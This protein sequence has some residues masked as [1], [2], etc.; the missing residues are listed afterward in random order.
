MGKNGKRANPE[1]KTS[2]V[3]ILK[4]NLPMTFFVLP[5]FIIMLINNYLPM[6]GLI[7][8]FKNMDN[9][10][11]IFKSPF[12]GFNNFKFLF[13][14]GRAFMITRNTV[15]YNLAFIILGLILSV[16]I[17]IAINEIRVR[18][19]AKAFQTII[20]LPYFLSFVVIGYIVYGFL[21]PELGFINNTLLPLLGKESIN[22]YSSLEYWPFILVFVNCWVY[23]GMNSIIY[24]ASMTAIDTTL[25]EAAVIDG[26]SKWNQ[27]RHITLPLIAPVMTIL[28][29]I[30]LGNIFRGNFGLFYQVPLANPI[31]IPVTD[32]LDTYIYR[33]LA[34]LGDLGMVTAASLYQ[35]VVGCVIIVSA[36][37]IIKKINPE[38]A[39]F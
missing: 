3:T 13:L 16:T 8:A 29:L 1:K 32:V 28:T 25:Y 22:W 35:S 30:N 33:S 36:N 10:L 9:S 2:W 37:H 11:G 27:I 39:M 24:S 12:A 14:S 21:S 17:A 19:L 20:I 38:N 15:L 18:L 31:L 6:S 7:M 34:T 5:G 23:C 26:A 4:K